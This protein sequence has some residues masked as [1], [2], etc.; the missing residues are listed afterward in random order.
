MGSFDY[1]TFNCFVDYVTSREFSKNAHLNKLKINL[2][3]SV[4][5]INKIYDNIVKL[6]TEYH[7]NVT[8][9]SIY[10]FLTISFNYLMNILMKTNYNILY[11]AHY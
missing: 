9:I 2:N 5:E 7:K 8:E 10:S 3:N 11:S 1:E 6:F 4:I